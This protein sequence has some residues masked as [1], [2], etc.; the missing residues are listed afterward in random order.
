MCALG[1]RC[2]D[3]KADLPDA[4][5]RRRRL[6][7]IDFMD[8]EPR[9]FSGQ[10]DLCTR[11]GSASLVGSTLKCPLPC[12]LA[13]GPEEGGKLSDTSD[14]MYGATVRACGIR[15]KIRSCQIN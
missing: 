13:P 8:K 12:L 10:V 14:A 4:V 11:A 2:T 5:P 1:A 6:V 9:L 7:P 3:A 15:R